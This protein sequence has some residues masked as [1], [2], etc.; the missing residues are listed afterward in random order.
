MAILEKTPSLPHEFFREAFHQI[1]RFRNMLLIVL[2]YVV[3]LIQ[4]E[5]NC[6]K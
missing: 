4:K 3:P 2:I 6:I 1:K 5:K